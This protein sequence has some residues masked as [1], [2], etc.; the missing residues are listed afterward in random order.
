M[1][2]LH[3]DHVTWAGTDLDVLR[4][5]M[6]EAGLPSAY[7]GAHANGV[8]HMAV[9]GFPDGSY[10]ELF[11]PH[12][13]DR[14]SPVWERAVRAEAGPAAWAVGC[15]DI[16]SEAVRLRDAGLPVRG[17]EPWSRKTPDGASAAWDLAFPGRGEPGS[18]LPFLIQDRTPR[19]LRVRPDPEVGRTGL[20]GVE[21]VVLLVDDLEKAADSF[22]AAFGW[23]DPREAGAPTLGAR[24]AAFEGTPVTLAAP[25]EPG[26]A[27]GA[28]GEAA[29]RLAARLESLGPAPCAFLLGVSDAS[30]VA[31]VV[32]TGPEEAWGEERV[33]WIP[34]AGADDRRLGVLWPA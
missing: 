21:R 28:A 33:R 15:Q 9:V 16:A 29:R 19:S 10:V 22:R 26:E 4:A 11:A 13:P 17:P 7:G 12:E 14:R 5:R 27:A 2:P 6:E 18:T 20:S 3:V 25:L 24:L 30:A 34:V 32:R 8:T 31:A 1:T 23:P